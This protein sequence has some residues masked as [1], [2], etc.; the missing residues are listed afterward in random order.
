MSQNAEIQQKYLHL[1]KLYETESRSKWH[2]LA[3]I[4]ELSNEVKTLRD[5][6]FRKKKKKLYISYLFVNL[7]SFQP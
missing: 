2:Y 6:V 4:E 7:F 1:S 5:E 3:Q